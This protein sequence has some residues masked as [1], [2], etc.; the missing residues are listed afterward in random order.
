MPNNT[1]KL[2][3]FQ[4]HQ[5][6][7]IP[8]DDSVVV[9]VG[10]SDS[11]KSAFVRAIR[12]ACLGGPAT[13]YDRRGGG[14]AAVE[15]KLAGVTVSRS[16]GTVVCDDEVYKAVG[17]KVPDEVASKLNMSEENF[18]LQMD[19]P[20]WVGESPT[21]LA[22]CLNAVVGLDHADRAVAKASAKSL[23]A[24]QTRKIR[25]EMLV[26]AKE[27]VEQLAWV[28]DCETEWNEVEQLNDQYQETRVKT[29]DVQLLY[30]RSQRSIKTQQLNEIVMVSGQVVL[31]S[32]E[33][34]RETT[35]KKR[36]L[37]TILIQLEKLKLAS[38]FDP[39]EFRQVSR[40]RDILIDIGTRRESV[41]SLCDSLKDFRRTLAK[42]K[43]ELAP[44]VAEK[45][46]LDQL[47][48]PT[49]GQIRPKK[50]L[51]YTR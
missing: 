32:L 29:A 23:K 49:C 10:P 36:Q 21:E 35:A 44:L 24:K 31:A 30:I 1:L 28:K 2:N 33:S 20:F 3:D 15:L 8:L 37:E 51:N 39:T 19:G 5:S 17:Q 43:S 27:K 50:K 45:E 18:Q 46:K 7:E 9:L 11:G 47:V 22:R 41:E 16:Q 40:E 42:I 38:K 4:C 25:K 12:W 48:C 14:K 13:G 34:I 26:A 6:V